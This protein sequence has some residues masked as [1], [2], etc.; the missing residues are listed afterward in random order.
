MKGREP[1]SNKNSAC[2]S[3]EGY[4]RFETTSGY[5]RCRGFCVF[6][7]KT[8]GSLSSNWQDEALGLKSGRLSLQLFL[9][10]RSNTETEEIK[11]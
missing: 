3:G 6:Y 1:S 4:R 7:P 2:E 11:P 8:L 9:L 10:R 5:T